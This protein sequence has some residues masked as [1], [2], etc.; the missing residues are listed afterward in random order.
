MR[1][2]LKKKTGKK[3]KIGHAG[4]LDPLASGL[5]IVLIGDATKKQFEF[6]KLDKTYQ[7]EAKLGE[8]SST[9]DEEGKKEFVS[10]LIPTEEQIKQVIKKFTGEIMQKPPVFS[11]IK[12]NGKRAYEL[13]RSGK[14]VK[15]KPRAVKIYEFDDVIYKYPNLSFT[16]SVSSGTY[17]RS[18]VED[19]GDYIKTGAYT[20]SL[21]RISIGKYRVEDAKPINEKY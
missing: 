19:I 17:I 20:K 15:L 11:A 1:N 21:R 9:G 4:T 7:V 14:Q 5:L 8:V 10:N 18:L 13:A 16:V 12:I 6:M 3:V 2:E